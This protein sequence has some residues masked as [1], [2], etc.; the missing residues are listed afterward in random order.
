[1][2]PAPIE[3]PDRLG[4][5]AELAAA[6]REGREPETS[7]QDNLRSLALVLAAIESARTRL[8]VE[9]PDVG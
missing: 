1:V 9:L 3:L 8:A 6:I 4:S 5:L 7:G 2:K